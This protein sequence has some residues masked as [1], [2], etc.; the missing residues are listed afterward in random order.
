MSRILALNNSGVKNV[1][2]F[3]C[4]FEYPLPLIIRWIDCIAYKLFWI[5]KEICWHG[6]LF[7][8]NFVIAPWYSFYLELLANFVF[9]VMKLYLLM[10][11]YLY[12]VARRAMGNKVYVF[13]I[14]RFEHPQSL[15]VLIVD[16]LEIGLF[17]MH[18]FS[19]VI[20]NGF[21]QFL[22]DKIV[23]KSWIDHLWYNKYKP[24]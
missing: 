14:G 22:I 23:I 20:A 1:E 12:Y 8:P 3:N 17:L 6:I 13:E 2:I 11:D 16:L 9:V 7:N 18:L 19:V 24:L 10:F 4:S 21:I 15:R 5:L